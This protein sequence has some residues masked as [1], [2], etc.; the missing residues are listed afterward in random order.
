MPPGLGANG[1][2]PTIEL[3][4]DGIGDIATEGRLLVDALIILGYVAAIMAIGLYAGR[5]E[6]SLHDYA[7]GGGLGDVQRSLAFRLAR[8]L[9]SRSH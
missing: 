8:F 7:L 9:A 6:K 3:G 5:R 1:R 4:R 2:S